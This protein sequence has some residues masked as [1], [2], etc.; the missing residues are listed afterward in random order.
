MSVDRIV[1]IKR[2]LDDQNNLS[3]RA[4]TKAV[5]FL[6]SLG[7]FVAFFITFLKDIAVNYFTII[8]L[9]IYFISAV[10]AMYNIIMTISPRTRSNGKETDKCEH[11]PYKAAFFGDICQFKN[12]DDYKASLQEMIKDEQIIEDVYSRQ[13]YEVSIVTAAKYKYAHRSVIYVLTAI[14]SEFIL[15]AYIFAS[16][17][18]V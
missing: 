2:I 10:L 16:K 7:L 15:V 18:I 1:A 13:V 5:A 8:I 12:V 6:T 14:S 17:A 4:D 3:A 11:N 9:A